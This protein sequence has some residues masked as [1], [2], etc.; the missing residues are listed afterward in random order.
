MFNNSLTAAPMLDH[1]DMHALFPMLS[2]SSF[3]C[4]SDSKDTDAPFESDLSPIFAAKTA[5]LALLT[6]RSTRKHTAATPPKRSNSSAT[7][8]ASAAERPVSAS[9]KRRTS[10]ST[11][12]ATTTTAARSSTPKRRRSSTSPAR[13]SSPSSSSLSVWT[14]QEK[15]AFFSAFRNKWRVTEQTPA[16]EATLSALLLQRCD[17]LSKRLKTKSVADVQ[18]F[19]AI[20]LNRI[21]SLLGALESHDVDLTN[22]DQVRIA[23]W[24]W[25]KLLANSRYMQECVRTIACVCACAFDSVTDAHVLRQVRDDCECERLCEDVPRARAAPVDHP[26]PPPDA[27]GQDRAW[28]HV[29]RRAATYCSARRSSRA[30]RASTSSTNRTEAS[31]SSN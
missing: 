11:A 6:P 15:S 8:A 22:A 21:A 13:A 4:E 27:Q 12:T 19:Y 29:Q 1:D 16:A 24:C 26:E 23:V 7:T 2:D 9:R 17:A 20:V 31:S 25:G 5:P 30:G 3:E 18:Q 14:A 10:T 28:E